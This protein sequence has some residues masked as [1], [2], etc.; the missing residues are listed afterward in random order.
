MKADKIFLS[1]K[2]MEFRPDEVKQ[3]WEDAINQQ[4]EINNNV[5]AR[6]KEIIRIGEEL[7]NS[8]VKKNV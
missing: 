3:L 1:L 5:I 8:E 2:A 6:L 4:K 7:K